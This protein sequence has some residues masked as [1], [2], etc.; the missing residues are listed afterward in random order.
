MSV[1]ISGA[2]GMLGHSFFRFFHDLDTTVKATD[3]DD[4]DITDID[5]TR[6]FLKEHNFDYW[7]N[8][9]AY[10]NIDR[11]ENDSKEAERTNVQSVKNLVALSKEAFSECGRAPKIIHFST[12]YVFDGTA[13]TPYDEHAKPRPLNIYAQTKLASEEIL[14][15][16]GCSHLIC[17]LSWLYGTHGRNFLKSIVE[18]MQTEE[19]VYVIDDQTGSPTFVDDIPKWVWK[20]REREG[21]FH[22]CNSESTSWHGLAQEIALLSRSLDIDLKVQLIEAVDSTSFPEQ[23][24]RPHYS[25]LDTSK[26]QSAGVQMRSWK[27]A[28]LDALEQL[29]RGEL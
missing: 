24:L 26:A 11:A 15:K 23:A 19:I 13:L 25:V 18:K 6:R 16:S 17:R 1:W 14:R 28:L 27:E 22:L 20:L 29:Q 21:L 5:A 4:V 12:D 9:S 8:C 7:I 3:R 2:H 10:T